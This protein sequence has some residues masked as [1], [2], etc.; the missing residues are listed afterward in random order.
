MNKH[1]V[2]STSRLVDEKLDSLKDT[3]KGLADQGAQK[4]DALKAK[5][6]EAKDQ[7]I[8][9]GTALLD[10]V[11]ELIRANPLKAVGIAFVAGFVGI[12]LFRRR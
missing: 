4:V 10:R 9:R 3:V 2:G 8:G 1:D 7:A 11:A 12:R 6:I 5:V